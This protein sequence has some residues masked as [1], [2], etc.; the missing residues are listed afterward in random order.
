M[1]RLSKAYTVP[2]RSHVKALH[3]F[4]FVLL[5]LSFVFQSYSWMKKITHTHTD[6]QTDRERDRQ[7]GRQL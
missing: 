6:R 1:L 2:D 5:F 7:T 3:G 4:S